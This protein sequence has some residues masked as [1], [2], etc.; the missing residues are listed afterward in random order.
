MSESSN[1]IGAIAVSCVLSVGAFQGTAD[2]WADLMKSGRQSDATVVTTKG[3]ETSGALD[4][5]TDRN[6]CRVTTGTSRA[7]SRAT[8]IAVLATAGFLAGRWLSHFLVND[9]N[10]PTYVLE[11]VGAAGGTLAGMAIGKSSRRDLFVS[12]SC[13]GSTP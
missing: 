3:Q 1:L 11:G 7:A 13:R 6:V 10:T 2:G 8:C 12:D 4:S 5:V 9:S